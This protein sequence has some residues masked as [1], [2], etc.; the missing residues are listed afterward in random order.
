MQ[1]RFYFNDSAGNRAAGNII[2]DKGQLYV[3][4]ATGEPGQQRLSER[5]LHHEQRT[6]IS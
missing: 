4:I 6:G 3:R 1:S 5:E 2:F